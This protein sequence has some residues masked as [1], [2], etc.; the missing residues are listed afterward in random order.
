MEVHVICMNDSVEFAVI[1]SEEQA[2]KKLDLL[3]A[4]NWERNRHYF[5]GYDNYKQ[6]CCWHIHTV[7]GE[8]HEA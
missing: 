1:G 3:Q 8:R 4:D 2:R 7:E 6:H 5:D